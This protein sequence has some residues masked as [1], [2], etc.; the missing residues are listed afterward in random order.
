MISSGLQEARSEREA[1]AL[2]I[3]AW[4][5]AAGVHGERYVGW[6]VAIDKSL[7]CSQASDGQYKC[8]AKA[9]PCT[10][11]QVPVNQAKPYKKPGVD[12]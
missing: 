1:R 12:G 5:T 11:S 7:T 3:S 2:A 4:V 10:I 6:H 9:L 8:L